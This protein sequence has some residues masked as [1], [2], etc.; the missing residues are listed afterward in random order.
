LKSATALSVLL[1]E[2]RRIA[3]NSRSRFSNRGITTGP[4]STTRYAQSASPR[5]RRWIVAA[6][7]ILANSFRSVLGIPTAPPQARKPTV[8]EYALAAVLI[9]AP[10]ALKSRRASFRKRRTVERIA[11]CARILDAHHISAFSGEDVNRPVRVKH[12]IDLVSYLDIDH[13]LASGEAA[14]FLECYALQLMSSNERFVHRA[15][16][17]ES[18]NPELPSSVLKHSESKLGGGPL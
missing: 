16:S 3:A 12:S 4:S 17:L 1:I 6:S 2:F 13:I 8:D 11:G 18:I 7:L 14:D 10:F 9:R 15:G 5:S